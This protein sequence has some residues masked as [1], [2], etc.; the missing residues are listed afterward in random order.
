ML[1]QC[2][3]ALERPCGSIDIGMEFAAAPRSIGSDGRTRKPCPRGSEVVTSEFTVDDLY[4]HRRVK[5]IHGVDGLDKAVCEIGDIDR[6]ANAYVSNLWEFPVDG[7]G[8]RQITYGGSDSSPRLSPSGAQVAFISHRSGTA[9]VFCLSRSGGEARKVGQFADGVST[10]RW[11]PSG[12]ELIV[13]ARTKVP[14]SRTGPWVQVP[15]VD[16]EKLDVEVAARLP[17]KQDGAGYVLGDHIHLYRMD[18]ATG[19]NV[20]LTD[21][22]FDVSSFDISADG[23]FVAYAR[24]R[25]G[26]FAHCTDL[27]VL[28]LATAQHRRMTRDVASVSGPVW[29]PDGS[30]IAFTGARNEGDAEPALW[31]VDV[32]RTTLWEVAAGQIDVADPA[33]VR[34]V[35]DGRSLTFMRAFRGRHQIAKV[36]AARGELSVLAAGDRQLGLLRTAGRRHVYTIEH[37]ALPSDVWSCEAGGGG[38]ARLSRLNPWW[39]DRPVLDARMRSFEVPDG[40]GGH[41]TIEGWLIQRAD[42][43]RPVALLDDVHGGPASYAAFDFDTNVYWRVLCSRGWAV[44][45]LNAVGSASY[46]REFCKRLCGHWGEF[47]LPQHLAALDTLRAGGLETD[48]LA[49]A[50]GSYGG[51]L[52]CWAT[53]HDTR[54]RSAVVMAPVGNIETHYGTSDGGYYADPWYMSSQPVFDRELARRLSPLQYVE[55]SVTPTLFMQGKDDERCPKC[56]SEELFVSLCRAADTPTQLVLYP[57][58]SHRFIGHGQPACRHDAAS[59]IV[60]WLEHYAMTQEPTKA[61]EHR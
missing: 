29:S 48:R 32:E 40:Q 17:Y 41:E 56:Q 27:W 7:P 18:V 55:R 26:R 25:E 44:L 2:A 51:Y 57:G 1:A 33:S 14:M 20:A 50:G 16:P 31:I 39:D 54:F 37:P 58:E 47:D 30:R 5:D 61:K 46:G 19:K 24:S 13:G 9:Q 28:D 49:I 21:G 34:W 36:D 12:R 43:T 53:G 60:A 4:L 10:I 23:R 6:D 38:E 42:I 52:S 22:A 15:T 8:G 3:A 35:D 45:A 11:M 59:R